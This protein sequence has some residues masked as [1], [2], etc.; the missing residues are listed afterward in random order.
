MRVADERGV[1]LRMDPNPDD[2]EWARLSPDVV[3]HRYPRLWGLFGE[4]WIE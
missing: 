1:R 4:H 2:V 3:A